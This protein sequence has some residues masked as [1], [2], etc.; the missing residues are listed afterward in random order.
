LCSFRI[1]TQKLGVCFWS[2]EVRRIF[3]RP[4]NWFEQRT[5]RIFSNSHKFLCEGAKNC[6][7]RWF[8]RANT[9]LQNVI[10]H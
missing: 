8:C 6:R 1:W 4:K 9:F 5:N 3:E 2:R 7:S 10:S